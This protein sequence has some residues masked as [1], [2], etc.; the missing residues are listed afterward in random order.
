MGNPGGGLFAGASMEGFL[1][2]GRPSYED[3]EQTIRELEEV[4]ARSKLTDALKASEEHYRQAVEN[5]PNP[6]FSID[7][8]GRIATWNS[9]CERVFQHRQDIVGQDIRVLFQAPQGVSSVENMVTRVFEKGGLND[10]E[11]SYLCSDDFQ[12]LLYQSVRE[13]LTNMV[14]HSRARTGMVSV[15]CVDGQLRVAVMD[16]GVGF[17]TTQIGTDIDGVGG[18]G[19]FSIKERLEAIGGTMNVESTRGGG[20]CVTLAAPLQNVSPTKT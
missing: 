1:M 13:L 17:D 14:K 10:V 9:A 15:S 3:L 16:D 8:K 11:L 18:F 4:V 6:I 5:S 2:T 20:T 7:S 19:L 12:I